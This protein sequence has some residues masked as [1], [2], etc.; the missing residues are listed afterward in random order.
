MQES[1]ERG[2]GAGEKEG[3]SPIL[4]ILVILAV[5]LINQWRN[6]TILL[7]R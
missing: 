5:Y 6:F 7:Q 2:R 1:V 4:K 3:G